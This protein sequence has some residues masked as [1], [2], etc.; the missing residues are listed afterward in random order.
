MTPQVTLSRP[1]VP[2]GAPRCLRINRPMERS[3]FTV[4]LSSLAGKGASEGL[5]GVR[6]RPSVCVDDVLA[7]SAQVTHRGAIG[8]IEEES[9]HGSTPHGPCLDFS[10]WWD[11]RGVIE[12]SHDSSPYESLRGVMTRLLKTSRVKSRHQGQSSGGIEEDSRQRAP[13]GR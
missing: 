4:A 8:G 1:Q 3:A 5:Y 12:R 7:A 6:A 9:G 2:P 11:R 10:H 13:E